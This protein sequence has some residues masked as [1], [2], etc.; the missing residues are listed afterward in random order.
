MKGLCKTKKKS[1]LR[2]VCLASQSAAAYYVGWEMILSALGPKT[3]I[4]ALTQAQNAFARFALSSRS[5][6]FPFFPMAS[7][8]RVVLFALYN[9]TGGAGWERN[10]NWNTHAKLSTW[11]KV[12][13]NDQGRVVKLSLSSTKLIGVSALLYIWG[14]VLLPCGASSAIILAWNTAWQWAKSFFRYNICV[15]YSVREVEGWVAVFPPRRS[16]VDM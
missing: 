2:Q 1:K 8:D 10:D 15:D 3:Q 13:V 5:G 12:E 14:V 4:S 6:R 7:S 9:A 11:S 16:F